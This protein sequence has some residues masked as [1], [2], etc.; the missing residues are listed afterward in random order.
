MQSSIESVNPIPPPPT[1]HPSVPVILLYA[2][3]CAACLKPCP[4]DTGSGTDQVYL[5]QW[6]WPI[7]ADSRLYVF[8]GLLD[9]TQAF[10]RP[11][12]RKYASG[13]RMWQAFEIL[14]DHPVSPYY[15]DLIQDRPYPVSAPAVPSLLH[16]SNFTST[17]RSY[18]AGTPFDLTQVTPHTR[19]L[20]SRTPYSVL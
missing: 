2:L 1:P 3:C 7:Y 11:E 5:N 8:A 14:S 6:R 18:Y 20:Y 17:M 10:S 19:P 13:R 16:A 15:D 9:F 4:T 12:G